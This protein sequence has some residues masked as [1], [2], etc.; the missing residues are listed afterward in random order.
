MLVDFVKNAPVIR[1]GTPNPKEYASNELY[2][3]PG[4]VAASVNILPKIGPTHGVQAP[5]NAAPK[6]NEVI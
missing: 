6:T 3:A 4:E 2:A 5:A 1:N